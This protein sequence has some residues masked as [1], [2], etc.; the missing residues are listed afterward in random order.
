MDKALCCL[1]A[2]TVATI[3]ICKNCLTFFSE[4]HFLVFQAEFLLSEPFVA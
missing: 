1:E 2:R 3:S 4:S